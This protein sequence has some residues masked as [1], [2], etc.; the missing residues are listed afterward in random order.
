M[1]KSLIGT[2]RSGCFNRQHSSLLDT[3]WKHRKSALVKRERHDLCPC[4]VPQS[5]EMTVE[6]M[7][8]IS[9]CYT[10]NCSVHAALSAESNSLTSH[11]NYLPLVYLFSYNQSEGF[12]PSKENG[13]THE[14]LGVNSDT[15]TS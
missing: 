13:L 14:K 11:F 7:K 9:Y 8:C 15:F 6:L 2:E 3:C 12:F 10:D 1:D 4:I 5:L